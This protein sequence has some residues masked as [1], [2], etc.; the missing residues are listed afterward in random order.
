MK[1]PPKKNE[2]KKS[3]SSKSQYVPD[4]SKR[5]AYGCRIEAKNILGGLEALNEAMSLRHGDTKSVM[6]RVVTTLA[7]TN[8]GKRSSEN[9]K[10][11]ANKQRRRQSSGLNKTSSSS[12]LHRLHSRMTGSSTNSVKNASSAHSNKNNKVASTEKGIAVKVDE[13][14]Q[15]GKEVSKVVAFESQPQQLQTIFPEQQTNNTVQ[16]EEQMPSANMAMLSPSL[17]FPAQL[18]SSSTTLKE[19]LTLF[20]IEAPA[21]TNLTSQQ[22]EILNKKEFDK[23]MM[24]VSAGIVASTPVKDRLKKKVDPPIP[25]TMEVINEITRLGGR[26]ERIKEAR[27]YRDNGKAIPEA[28]QTFCE[29]FMRST[30][31]TAFRSEKYSLEEVLFGQEFT[32]EEWSYYE[33]LREHEQSAILIGD[34]DSL[35]VA[36]LLDTNNDFDVFLVS[37][38]DSKP[39]GPIKISTF[40]RELKFA[41]RK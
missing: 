7:S 1:M 35:I 4:K 40:L 25:L 14:Q 11:S 8:S 36:S 26:V 2:K 39:I 19:P 33:Y 29:A 16:Q 41:Q 9:N 17:A 23:A 3:S 24:L 31:Q 13:R 28:I 5:V 6:R 32:L 37:D 30:S 22:P 20:T 34:G 27:C 15:K 18:K 10:A 21:S 38:E 12:K